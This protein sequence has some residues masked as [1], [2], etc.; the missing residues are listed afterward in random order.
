MGMV[1]SGILCMSWS[2]DNE[3][4]AFVTGNRTVLLMT[5]NWDVISENPIPLD[6]TAQVENP[7]ISWRGDGNYFACLFSVEGS[8]RTRPNS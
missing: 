2:P 3:I 8:I 6:G 7:R 1:D 5:K 4:V